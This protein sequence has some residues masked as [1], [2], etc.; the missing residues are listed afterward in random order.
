MLAYL[1]K[2]RPPSGL[3]LALFFICLVSG[4]NLNTDP[5]GFVRVQQLRILD[6][7]LLPE[8][9][10]YESLGSA[11]GNGGDSTLMFLEL[12]HKSQYI[13]QAGEKLQ[14]Y[15]A[16]FS[17]LVFDCQLN[18][19]Y[20][21]L[22]PARRLYPLKKFVTSDGLYVADYKNARKVRGKFWFYRILLAL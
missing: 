3:S 5:L 13:T 10:C 16:P 9:F 8:E 2:V 15:D 17:L 6:S 11:I 22:I 18:Q 4:C 7:I 19:L 1:R 12:K 14:Y 21:I 20:E